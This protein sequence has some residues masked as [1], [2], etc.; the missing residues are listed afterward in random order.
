MADTIKGG[1]YLQPDG[2]WV[3]ANGKKIPPPPFAKPAAAPTPEPS[4]PAIVAPSAQDEYAKEP[5]IVAPDKQ[6]VVAPE[7]KET[8]AQR[9]ERLKA[10]KAAKKAAGG[11]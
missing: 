5:E 9:R 1:A 7:V 6:V 3:N 4:A 11:K 8:A 10:E 2:T